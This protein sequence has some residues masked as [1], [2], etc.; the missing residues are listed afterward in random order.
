M[1][2]NKPPA[3]VILSQ[4][5]SLLTFVDSLERNG[6]APDEFSGANNGLSM[7]INNLAAIPQQGSECNVSTPNE[8]NRIDASDSNTCPGTVMEP[9]PKPKPYIMTTFN[10]QLGVSASPYSAVEN[11]I[12]YVMI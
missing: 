9:K 3:A 10:T 2:V 1:D 5:G 11:N 6:S 12:P 8:H 4:R 7:D